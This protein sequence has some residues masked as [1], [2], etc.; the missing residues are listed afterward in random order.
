M[1]AK[2]SIAIFRRHNT[3]QSTKPKDETK[4]VNQRKN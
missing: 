3:K 4:S 1:I 2:H